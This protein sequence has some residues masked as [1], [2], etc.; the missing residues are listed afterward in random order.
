VSRLTEAHGE[1]GSF[2]PGLFE[3]TIRPITIC[4]STIVGIGVKQHEEGF[5]GFL[6]EKLSERLK[7]SVS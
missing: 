6:S 4:V 1:E 3:K 7:V 2:N 5:T